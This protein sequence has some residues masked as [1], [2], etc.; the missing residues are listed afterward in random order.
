MKKIKLPPK[1]YYRLTHVAKEFGCDIDAL[2]DYAEQGLLEICVRAADLPCDYAYDVKTGQ[3]VALNPQGIRTGL[4]P[5][6]AK[7]IESSR[8]FG[9]GY[10]AYW[11]PIKPGEEDFFYYD[12]KEMFITH[13]EK[14]R[15]LNPHKE[16]KKSVACPP[17]VDDFPF[18][19]EHRLTKILWKIIKK[20]P[21]EKRT[22]STVVYEEMCCNPGQAIEISDGYIKAINP[23]NF[24]LKTN[25][26][27]GK[28]AIK[29]R[30]GR[31]LPYL[32]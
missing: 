27:K 24:I 14:E 21:P 30:I 28:D 19:K 18:K 17:V 6:T 32:S 7:I 23:G 31:L 8:K 29:K 16:E 10:C 4:V 1:K 11:S 26:L 2:L 15:F 3:G 20:L 5:V 9:H 12:T 25:E 13:E 22:S